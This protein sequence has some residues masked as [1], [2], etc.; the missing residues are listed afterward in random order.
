MRGSK[1]IIVRDL[2]LE[3]GIAY[4]MFFATLG[5]QYS[6]IP[7]VF[8]EVDMSGL[9]SCDLWVIYFL[10][11]IY[12]YVGILRNVA[13]TPEGIIYPRCLGIKSEL[14]MWKELS[15]G[16]CLTEEKEDRRLTIYKY[17]MYY[18]KKR[19]KYHS[20][21]SNWN[22][23]SGCKID[24]TPSIAEYLLAYDEERANILSEI[25]VKAENPDLMVSYEEGAAK[26]KRYIKQ[27]YIFQLSMLILSLI[28]MLYEGD[29]T[30]AIAICVLSLFIWSFFIEKAYQV[31]Y[32]DHCKEAYYHE[33][34]QQQAV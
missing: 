34:I 4:L 23:V 22:P 9:P 31:G 7:H 30:T 14:I 11:V 21:F 25:M 33:L 32:I 16:V 1:G 28:D 26:Y 24:L 20:M 10:L 5:F 12:E 27:S 29:R 19:C 15:Y 8:D 17:T 13:L 18:A 6:M 3:N 2:Y